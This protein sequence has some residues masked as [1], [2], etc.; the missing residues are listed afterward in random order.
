VLRHADVLQAHDREL[1]GLDPDRNRRLHDLPRQPDHQ[2]HRGDRGLAMTLLFAAILAGGILVF[3]IGLAMRPA[4]NTADM[5]QERLQA[6]GGE[7]PM[8]LE[9]IELQKPFSD[10]FIRPLIEL[11][12]QRLAKSTPEKARIDLQN[13]LNR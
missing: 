9:E 13:R 10:R 3:F 8:T 6:Y 5:V 7:K 1:R 11:L 12:G 2:P 4:M